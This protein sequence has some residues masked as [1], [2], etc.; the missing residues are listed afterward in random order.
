MSSTPGNSW[1]NQPEKHSPIPNSPALITAPDCLFS[2]SSAA[3]PFDLSM[4]PIDTVYSQ[5][6]CL[7]VSIEIS[8]TLF[9]VSIK[10]AGQQPFVAR[11]PKGLTLL[12]GSSSF[13]VQQAYAAWKSPFP[14]CF[15]RRGTR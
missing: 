7:L 13:S 1:R 4:T 11:L 6:R 9:N 14:H 5:S 3:L 15:C 8:R 12:G 2:A 10:L